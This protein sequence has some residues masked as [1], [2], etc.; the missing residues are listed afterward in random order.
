[1]RLKAMTIF[2]S[3]RPVINSN[4]GKGINTRLTRSERS[5]LDAA[6]HNGFNAARADGGN[7][8]PPASYS[9]AEAAAFFAG[10]DSAVWGEWSVEDI[11]AA[12]EQARREDAMACGF[13]GA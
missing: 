11:E 9:D 2:D 13:V 8:A 10:A 12:A 6:W 5:A 4:F 1:L 7:V 3:T